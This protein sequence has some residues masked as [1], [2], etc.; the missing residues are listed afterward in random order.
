MGAR[1]LAVRAATTICVFCVAAG[2][3]HASAACPGD[4]AVPSAASAPTAAAALLCDIN[5]FRA[6]AGLPALRRNNRL[7][8]AAQ[9]MASQM[10]AN[11]RF[12]HTTRDGRTLTDRVSATGYTARRKRWRLAE[13][14]GWGSLTLAP[15][16][17]I[18]TGWMGSPEHR[19]NMLD[20][21][22]RDVGIGIAE[23]VPSGEIESGTFYVADFGAGTVRKRA[24]RSRS[25]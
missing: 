3:A 19:S 25:R 8:S 9:D 12:A 13:N 24:H 4:A 7:Q 10:A 18:V 22:L 21:G 2:S 14:I 15:P 6:R 1:G 23:G 20:P 16:V 11:H 17:S 5:A